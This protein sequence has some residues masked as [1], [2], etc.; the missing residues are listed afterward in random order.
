[1]TVRSWHLGL[2]YRAYTKLTPSATIPLTY[3]QPKP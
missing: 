1:M 2:L 3:S